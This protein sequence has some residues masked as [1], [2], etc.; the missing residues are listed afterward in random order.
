M[1]ATLS[2]SAA[3]ELHDRLAQALLLTGARPD[4]LVTHL[5]HARPRGNP[6]AR[7]VLEH[8][9]RRALRDGDTR[10]GVALLRRALDEGPG[11]SD[12]AAL[13]SALARGL[14]TLGDVTGAVACWGQAGDLCTDPALALEYAAAA[15]DAL[16]DAGRLPEA[17]AAYA[18]L[19]ADAPPETRRWVHDRMLL[20]S[21][22]SGLEPLDRPDGGEAPGE[23]ASI[24]TAFALANKS[25][26]A[27]RVAVLARTAAQDAL[28]GRLPVRSLLLST[29]LLAAASAFDDA[30]RL[31]SAAVDAPRDPQTALIAA[32][33]RGL[34]RVRVGRVT[35]GLADLERAG[36][37]PAAA[38]PAQEVAQVS[39]VV[40]G[41]LARGDLAGATRLS[42]GLNRIPQS[43]GIA[44]ALARH[45]L[46]EVAGAAG[47]HVLATE[48]YLD[49]GR[50]TGADVDNPGLLPWRVGAA[51]A[52][53]RS[54]SAGRALELARENLRL[55]RQFGAPYAEAQALRTVAAVDV[56][57]DRVGLL[58]QA[59][60]VVGAVPALRLRAQIETD[61]AAL[62][63]LTPAHGTEA[64]VLLRAVDEYAAHEG[65]EPL[66]GRARRLLDRLG[67]PRPSGPAEALGHP[68]RGRAAHRPAGRGGALQ[69]V[70]RRAARGE[71]EGGRVA[72]VRLLPQA[73]HPVAAPAG[74][75][76]HGRL[77][78][79]GRHPRDP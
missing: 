70:D 55:A 53:I 4:R 13:A 28:E 47:D 71:R 38:G 62:L 7:L 11:T 64:L 8:Q 33:C 68:D 61:L 22:V 29:A 63:T 16:A 75:R 66:R 44:A 12:D 31:L 41:L 51:L 48:L 24:S 50:C 65:L 73:R 72:P 60:D 14:V 76:A 3:A 15:A 21:Y 52:E 5:L 58:R 17:V 59:L 40:D 49:A 19:A 34:V 46:A 43:T 18:A 6:A 9:G 23:T 25:L 10:L 39:A 79:P 32:A 26:A 42:A 74:R 78:A 67:E 2:R 56:T 20:A 69:P 37:H 77:T 57:A 45:T 27:D 1:L 36:A 35:E 30:D 54:G